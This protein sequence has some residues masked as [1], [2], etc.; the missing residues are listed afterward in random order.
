MANDSPAQPSDAD[1]TRKAEPTT[2]APP[3]S[4]P[5]GGGAIRGIGEKF[6]VNSVSG[7]GSLSVPIAASP[8]REGFG[9]NLSL[10]YD[11][12]AGNGPFGLGWSLSL[13]AI[14]RR[15]DLSL[16]HISEPT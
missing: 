3:I 14:T 16:I 11:S 6:S 1:Q 7:T 13:P 12:G 5:K 9:P 8:G 10:N 4:L 15:T 2:A